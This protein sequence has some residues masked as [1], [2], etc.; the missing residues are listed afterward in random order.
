MARSKHARARIRC[1][2]DRVA[3]LAG[4]GI[5][6]TPDRA[7]LRHL[8]DVRDRAALRVQSHQ[9][10]HLRHRPSEG[11]AAHDRSGRPIALAASSGFRDRRSVGMGV[12]LGHQRRRARHDPVRGT[13]VD[14]A[15][16]QPVH[17]ARAG[18]LRDA[19]LEYGRAVGFPLADVYVV[20]GRGVRRRRTRSSPGSAATGGS[21]SSTRCSARSIRAR[22]WPWWRTRSATG[23]GH[24]PRGW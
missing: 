15:V 2:R 12:G 3:F 6:R 4:L 8:V 5:A 19:I 22:W 17:A 20:D 1:G 13:G 24:V 9:P 7:A 21:P 18:S 23:S 11:P 14:H 10:G 16:V